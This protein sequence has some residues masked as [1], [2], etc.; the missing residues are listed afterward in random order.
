[1]TE[2]LGYVSHPSAGAV[3]WPALADG[4][5]PKQSEPSVLKLVRQRDLVARLGSTQQ[6]VEMEPSRHFTQL[7]AQR[8]QELGIGPL[9]KLRRLAHQRP[10]PA[11]RF[12]RGRD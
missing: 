4:T 2:A 3:V 12:L 1:M 5:L 6:K 7:R 11:I 10:G 8:N 9:D